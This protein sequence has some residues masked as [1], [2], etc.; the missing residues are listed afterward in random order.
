MMHPHALLKKVDDVIGYG[1]F[2]SKL[3][4]AGSVTYARDDSEWFVCPEEYSMMDETQKKEVDWFSYIDSDGMRIVSTDIARYMNHNC[5]ANTISTGY[6]FEI[7]VRDIQPG[8]EI[9]DEYGLF[10]L[11]EPMKCFC[12]S[13]NCRTVIREDDWDRY[14]L[15]WDMKARI[16]LSKFDK[17]YQPL[18]GYIDKCLIKEVQDYLHGRCEM[19]S[20]LA[21]RFDAISI[22]KTDFSPLTVKT[23]AAAF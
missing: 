15:Q 11:P 9:T 5:D 21:L 22:Q 12:G 13:A 19:K 2:A 17:V 18:A 16:G 4:P 6:G 8:Q 10:S 3:I 1:V 20:V 23:A 14:F 7:A